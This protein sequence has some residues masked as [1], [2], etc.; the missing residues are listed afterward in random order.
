VLT[1]KPRQPTKEA[2]VSARISVRIGG[3]VGWF[4][5]ALAPIPPAWSYLSAQPT[6][7]LEP[8]PPVRGENPIRPNRFGFCPILK[9]PR[10]RRWSLC[11][12]AKFPKVM[13]RQ[14]FTN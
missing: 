4:S 10:E 11:G 14:N 5:W 7:P 9:A 6:S 13:S 8:F 2:Q 12:L 1:V 3:P